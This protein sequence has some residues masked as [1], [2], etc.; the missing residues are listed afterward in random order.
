MSYFFHIAA[1]K[2][3]VTAEVINW[4]ACVLVSP[5]S[6]SRINLFN[7][8][9]MKPIS[10]TVRWYLTYRSTRVAEMKRGMEVNPRQFSGGYMVD[11]NWTSAT[12]PARITNDFARRVDETY[13]KSKEI[14]LSDG[15]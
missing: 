5:L 4:E 1:M 10:S 6:M 8:D 15:G 14:S 12:D 13:V 11:Q 7:N 9:I 3:S 2:V